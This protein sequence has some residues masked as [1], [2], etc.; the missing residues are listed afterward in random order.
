MVMGIVAQGKGQRKAT[1]ARLNASVHLGEDLAK[2]QSLD[3]QKSK[4]TEIAK[5]RAKNKSAK[6]SRKRNR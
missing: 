1:I 2:T 6:Q 5:R 3:Y 4:S